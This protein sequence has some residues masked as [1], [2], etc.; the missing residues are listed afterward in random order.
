MSK[1]ISEINEGFINQIEAKRQ[2]KREK[3]KN[4]T[5][6]DRKEFIKGMVTGS[7][8]DQIKNR[9]DVGRGLVEEISMDIPG[10]LMWGQFMQYGTFTA[11]QSSWFYRVRNKNTSEGETPAVYTVRGNGNAPQRVMVQDNGLVFVFPERIT[12]SE[13]TMDKFSLELGLNTDFSGIKEEAQD[14]IMWQLEDRSFALLENGL[15][16]DITT[17]NGVN[18]GS[19]V[20]E[21]PGSNK[22]DL[23]DQNGITLVTLKAIAKYASLMGKKIEAIYTPVSGEF[24]IWDWA[25]VPQKMETVSSSSYEKGNPYEGLLVIPEDVRRQIVK[26]GNPGQLFG[27]N[28]N[29]TSN[30]TLEGDPTN[31]DIYIWVKLSG[32]CGHLNFYDGS[33]LTNEYIK[34]DANNIY[35]TLMKNIMFFQTPEDRTNYLR[36]KIKNKVS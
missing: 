13:Y 24:D 31:D 26:T 8:E 11:D 9:I 2:E 29:I 23:A 33:G 10:Q 30:N 6:A 21:V 4:V 14:D 28:F 7:K 17:L 19:R 35:Y 3:A 36:V 1:F 12:S 5:D 25:E 15:Y 16:D 18:I 34:D 27:R 20:K 22:L 32:A